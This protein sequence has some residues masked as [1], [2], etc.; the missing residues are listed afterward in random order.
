MSVSWGVSLSQDQHAGSDLV[1]APKSCLRACPSRRTH[2]VSSGV[3]KQT[4]QEE[5]VGLRGSH[6]QDCCF[7]WWTRG[8]GRDTPSQQPGRKI[9]LRYSLMGILEGQNNSR[10]PSSCAGPQT[11]QSEA[12]NP[13]ALP[14]APLV[15]WQGPPR[16]QPS[17]HMTRGP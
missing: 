1:A 2:H 12:T 5:G 7:C 17:W 10:E 3:S 15:L 6:S 16:C 13:G 4:F 14:P 11:L 8:R 9:R